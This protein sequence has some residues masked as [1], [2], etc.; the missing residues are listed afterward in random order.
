VCSVMAWTSYWQL[1]VDLRLM[2]TDALQSWENIDGCRSWTSS[3]TIVIYCCALSEVV[4]VQVVFLR[5]YDSARWSVS[6]GLL[7]ILFMITWAIFLLHN[8]SIVRPRPA[9]L[10]TPDQAVW[11]PKSVIRATPHI[12]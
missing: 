7:I 11:E 1:K 8:Q 5:V 4:Y 12:L 10:I 3:V 6:S 2:V 9:Q